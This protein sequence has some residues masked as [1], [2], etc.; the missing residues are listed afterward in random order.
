MPGHKNKKKEAGKMGPGGENPKGGK[1]KTGQDVM[2]KAE[3]ATPLDPNAQ[4]Q[5]KK[6][7]K[8]GK[9]KAKDQKKKE[10]P[11]KMKAVLKKSD[12]RSQL[13]DRGMMDESGKMKKGALPKNKKPAMYKAEGIYKRVMPTLMKHNPPKGSKQEK[14][15]QPYIEAPREPTK[16]YKGPGSSL[17]G[18]RGVSMRD[19]Y[20]GSNYGNTDLL[21][22][23]K[24][25]AKAAMDI[26]MPGPG[27]ISS[28]VS[29]AFGGSKKEKKGK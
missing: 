10:I 1:P 3:K 19:S 12:K 5:M 18:K 17:F 21:P 7:E 4:K 13:G 29:R 20:G 16:Y 22:Y 2:N 11:G 8:G 28:L 14:S 9:G 24:K 26:M 25:G 23:I 6:A 15:K 27:V